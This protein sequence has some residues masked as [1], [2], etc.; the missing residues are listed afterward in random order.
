MLCQ[1]LKFILSAVSVILLY[2][3]GYASFFA[4]KTKQEKQVCVQLPTSADN[5][6]LPALATAHCRM[7]QTNGQT[8]ARQMHRPCTTYYAGSANK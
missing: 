2:I 6:A 5:V 8:D 3:V 4:R 7:G 1:I